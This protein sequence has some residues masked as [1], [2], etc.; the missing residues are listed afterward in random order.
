M[1][2]A[3]K[4]QIYTG[5]IATEWQPQE[6][7]MHQYNGLI[8]TLKKFSDNNFCKSTDKWK[9]SVSNNN[10]VT[11]LTMESWCTEIRILMCGIQNTQYCKK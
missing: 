7:C 11:K 1:E 3:E 8:N 10:M 2:Y 5:T 6:N 9:Y 4:S